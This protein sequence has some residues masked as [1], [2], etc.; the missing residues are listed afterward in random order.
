MT[1]LELN[2]LRNISS[3]TVFLEDTDPLILNK[4]RV[5]ANNI[6]VVL[7]LHH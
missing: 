3:V 7:D 5:A 4:A 2:V 1:L 6:L